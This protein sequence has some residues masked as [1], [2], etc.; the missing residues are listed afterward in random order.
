MCYRGE[1]AC[2]D[3]LVY[4]PVVPIEDVEELPQQSGSDPTP[5]PAK[6]K[7]SDSQQKLARKRSV[8]IDVVM[9]DAL[10]TQ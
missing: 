4:L 7:T 6:L 5:K 3:E 9:H 2:P 10:L 1:D 8:F